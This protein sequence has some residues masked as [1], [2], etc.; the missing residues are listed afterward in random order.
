MRRSQKLLPCPIEPMP[1]RSKME[2][3]LVKAEPISDCGSASETRDLR[4][5][6]KAAQQE[7]RERSET[8]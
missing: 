8:V 1:A 5:G 3:P 7:L 6:E 2:P 4:N